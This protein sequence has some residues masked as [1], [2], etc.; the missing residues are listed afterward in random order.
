MPI[1]LRDNAR[2]TREGS[3]LQ[4]D[5]TYALH[6]IGQLNR[7]AGKKWVATFSPDGYPVIES[8]PLENKQA[9]A[10]WLAVEVERHLDA[11]AEDDDKSDVF[12]IMTRNGMW[13]TDVQ[14]LLKF[15]HKSGNQIGYYIFDE[16]EASTYMIRNVRS[17]LHSFDHPN[18]DNERGVGLRWQKFVVNGAELAG[19]IA[20]EFGRDIISI[21]RVVIGAHEFSDSKFERLEMTMQH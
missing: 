21:D 17:L 10:E 12:M 11:L 6:D 8:S 5:V 15:V 16:H 9:A 1:E 19:S 2:I 13:S 4:S 14:R 3:N 7:I 18:P 20:E